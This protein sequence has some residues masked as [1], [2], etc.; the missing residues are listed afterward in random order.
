MPGV[1]ETEQTLTK[2]A[3]KTHTCAQVQQDI[4][5]YFDHSW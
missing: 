1:G 3:G 5:T 2:S 4:A